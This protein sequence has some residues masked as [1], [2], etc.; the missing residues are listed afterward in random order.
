VSANQLRDTFR[1]RSSQYRVAEGR[2]IL[3]REGVTLRLVRGILRF[4]R[5]PQA[6]DQTRD[7]GPLVLARRFIS[8]EEA[9]EFAIGL[10][11]GKS[12]SLSDIAFEIPGEYRI[13][14][15]IGIPYTGWPIPVGYL[16]LY[17]W[18]AT[19][20]AVG[21]STTHLSI[22]SGPFVRPGLPLIV[23]GNYAASEWTGVNPRRGPSELSNALGVILP[24]YRARIR[25]VRI[26]E[27]RVEVESE[28]N[29]EE[30]K[31]DLRVMVEGYEVYREVAIARDGSRFTFGI[32]GTPRFIYVFLVDQMEGTMLDWAL[33]NF[34]S[35]SVVP[36]VEFASPAQHLA[37]L[38]EEGENEEVEFKEML[39]DGRTFIQS[40]VGFA[41][42]Q[43]GTILVGVSDD[44][45]IIGTK[46]REDQQRI[47]EWMETRLDP[48]VT[49]TF[50][51]VR[52]HEKEVLV[53]RVPKGTNPPY[54]HRD[55]G[56]VYVRRGATD[57]PA[58][59]PELD[60]FYRGG[61]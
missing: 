26:G 43:G 61:R 45:R 57:R 32:E 41:N 38:L 24:D 30:L 56:V 6:E 13:S 16:R 46:Q 54:Q 9:I 37:R 21:T 14:G 17:D 12:A 42:T 15:P 52:L 11:A 35:Q 34:M 1:E 28:V 8:T 2:L 58:R 7:Y 60:E 47:A 27:T 19:I 4:T 55:N 53:V 10:P 25:R 51:T 39:G 48:P 20:F 22:P 49:V 59:R 36:E 5:S 3:V 44:A 40:V 18:P 33:I 50:E 23:D 29:V 31:V